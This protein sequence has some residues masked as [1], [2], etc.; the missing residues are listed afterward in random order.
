MRVL[1]Y[2]LGVIE[3][4]IMINVVLF[5]VFS[6]TETNFI[7][8]VKNLALVPSDVMERPWTLVTSMFVH[9][10]GIDHIIFNMVSLFFFGIYLLQ[11]INEKE[12]LKLYFVGGI[13]GGLLFVATSL[14]LGIPRPFE[15]AVGASGA[16]FALGGALAILRPNMTVFIFPIPFP[17]P[18]YLAVF[19]FMVF[20]SFLPGVAWQAHL[21]GLFIGVLYGRF[22]VK[23]RPLS[24]HLYGYYN[25]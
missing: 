8:A 19:G 24:G 2:D 10:R 14:F 5:L 11:L 12:V 17:M 13:A 6:T 3:T 18:L 4:L 25:R 21:G 16:I 20:L 15:A 22:L 9:S 1:G 23:R 7:W